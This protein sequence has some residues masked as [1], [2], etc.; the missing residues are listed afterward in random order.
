MFNPKVTNALLSAIAVATATACQP[1]TQGNQGSNQTNSTTESV[2]TAQTN[3]T[4]NNQLSD[5]EFVNQAAESS[6]AEVQL[7]NLAVQRAA[8]DDVKQYAQRMIQE[9]TQSN[10][11]LATLAKQKNL[12]IPQNL[13]AK[14]QAVKASLSALSGDAFDRAYMTQMQQDH[15]Q[16]V[17]LF[18][19][20]ATQGQDAE[21][22]NWAATLL[23]QLQNHEAMAQKIASRL[24]NTSQQ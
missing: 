14:H 6:L 15:D 16:V 10:Q 9:H 13:N 4:N 24:N 2:P 18:Q 21:L 5:Q 20:E 23:P 22:K 17:A 3:Q 19:R 12:T 11:Q 1:A 8:S 7:G